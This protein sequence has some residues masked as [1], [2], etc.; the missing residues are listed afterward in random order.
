[1]MM[2]AGRALIATAMVFLRRGCTVRIHL[3]AGFREQGANIDATPIGT[4]NAGIQPG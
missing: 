4:E 3:A 1:M 2:V